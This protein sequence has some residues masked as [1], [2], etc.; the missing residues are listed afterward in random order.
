MFPRVVTS[1]LVL[2]NPSGCLAVGE[3]TTVSPDIR[4]SSNDFQT[5]PHK[6]LSMGPSRRLED[7]LVRKLP[8][9]RVCPAHLWHDRS[10]PS[11]SHRVSPAGRCDLH[12]DKRQ[13]ARVWRIRA[14]QSNDERRAVRHH[15]KRVSRCALDFNAFEFVTGGDFDSA[16]AKSPNS[17]IGF[18]LL[19]LQRL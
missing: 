6:N 13:P 4:A 5:S 9:G 11:A 14:I 1:L 15:V 18:E 2:L 19:A 17:G 12:F 3:P 7:S 8:G 10:L 16:A